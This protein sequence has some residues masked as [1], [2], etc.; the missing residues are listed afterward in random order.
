MVLD[1]RGVE[2]RTGGDASSPVVRG[3][4]VIAQRVARRVCEVGVDV[5]GFVCPVVPKGQARIRTQMNA[6]LTREDLDRGLDAFA[7][8]GRELG[9]T[10]LARRA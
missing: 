2:L 4:A 9:V 1:G 10:S 3:E 7:A 6:A 8:A 5:S